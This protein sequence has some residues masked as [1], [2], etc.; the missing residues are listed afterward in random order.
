MDKYFAQRE[1]KELVDHLQEFDAD[2]NNLITP[3]ENGIGAVWSRNINIYY[4]NIIYGDSG[5][6]LGFD[7][8]QGELVK[9]I[10]P[11][12]RSLN[13]QFLSLTTKQKLHFEPQ[14]LSTEALALSDNR[15][16]SALCDKVVFEQQMD[17]KSY[18]L[19][20]L[21]SLFGSAY[22]F[23]KW[24][25]SRGKDVGY[26]SEQG[27]T[28]YT[29]S[30]RV[31]VHSPLDLAFDYTI[32]NFQDQD[33]VRIRYLAN[34]WDLI[35]EF[36]DLEEGVRRLPKAMQESDQ[37]FY[38]QMKM[39]DDMVWVYE[40]L[41][42]TTAALPLGRHTVYCDSNTVFHDDDN[43]YRDDSGAFIPIT[44]MKPEPIAGTGFGYPIFCNL[45]PLQEMLD[46][47]FSAIASNNNAYAVKSI[48][49]PTGND[50]N[51][52]HIQNLKFI[53]YKP[54]N[55][56]GGGRPEILD[57]NSQNSELYNFNQTIIQNM[58]QIYA[59]NSAI[60]G[61][62]GAGITSGTAIATLS[63][64][65]IEFAQNFTKAYVSANERI[66]YYA[67]LCYRNFAKYP[68]IVAV[69]GPNDSQ[70]AKEFVGSDL[71]TISRVRC[72]IANPLM[73][74]AAGKLEIA[75][76]LLQTGQ[77]NPKKYFKI[78][79]G[80]P[81]ES[82]FD[83]EINE[84]SYIQEE[85]DELRKEDGEEVFAFAEDDHPV[86]IQEHKSLL[87]N[88]AV[89]KNQA[90]SQ[91]IRD[92]IG[93]HYDLAK[94]TDALL[95]QMIKTGQIPEAIL[96]QNMQMQMMQQQQ[97]MM[98]PPPMP[99]GPEGGPPQGPPPEGAGLPP[100]GAMAPPN[101]GPPAGVAE[102]QQPLPAIENQ[103]LGGLAPPPP[104]GV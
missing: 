66:M 71:Q 4:N 77:I 27:K 47:N 54:M 36:P 34:R 32:E 91:K 42:R 39:N 78:L 90:L 70:M 72:S 18:R 56:Q 43:A 86:H 74:T 101:L 28:V 49:N 61:E 93:E 104:T 45:I 67:I 2:W 7:G 76:N 59:I 31:S 15:V 75:N 82:L 73:A 57:L 58:Q 35:A 88:I 63:A 48:L 5:T 85:N 60:R 80:A 12:A 6:S 38:W 98:G 87:D 40:F 22:Y 17:E 41:H 11:Q 19:A 29:G 33:W 100:P 64:N 102:P 24:D 25:M 55:V 79:E 20:E 83:K 50:I 94:N 92:H 3:Q 69:T 96:A 21:A 13:T 10:V 26:D 37:V 16:A 14:A 52:K 89:R 53:N 9:M 81:I 62:P 65:A 99:M 1:S 44:E 97:Q 51:V 84:Q 46:H 23:V 68:D 30:P 8:D 103:N 95:Y